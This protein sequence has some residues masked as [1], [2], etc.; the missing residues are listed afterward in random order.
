VKEGEKEGGRGEEELKI[1]ASANTCLD[2]SASVFATP[3]HYPS[4][5]RIS[6]WPSMFFGCNVRKSHSSC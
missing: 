3:C 2:L 1:N 5:P 4:S 6:T